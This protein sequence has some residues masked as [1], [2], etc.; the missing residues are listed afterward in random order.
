MWFKH[1]KNVS[2]VCSTGIAATRYGELWVQ[3]LHKWFGIEDGKHLNQVII[4]LVKPDEKLSKTKNNILSVEIIIL[5]KISMFIVNILCRN[6]RNTNK[7]FGNIQFILVGDSYLFA[8]N[9]MPIPATIVLDYP[10]LIISPR[11]KSP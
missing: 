10:S 4:Q 6:I 7:L 1:Q 11:H 3:T 5:D 2:I 9:Y 8:M